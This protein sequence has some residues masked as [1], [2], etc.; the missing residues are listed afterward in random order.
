MNYLLVIILI[1]LLVL[2]HELGHLL[3]ARWVKMPVARFSIG[4]G[5]RLWGFRRGETEYWLSLLPVG[6]YVLPKVADAEGFLMMPLYQRIIF[7]LGGPLA[8]I[9]LPL[10]LFILMN[11]IVSGFSWTGVFIKPFGQTLGALNEFMRMIPKVLTH[12]DQ[13]TGVVGIVAQGGPFVGT[14]VVRGL[15]FCIFLSLNLAVFN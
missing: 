9:L 8:N 4:F 6:G 7:A 5:P 13:S 3:A 10:F 1:G 15:R 11:I 14:S 2:V 12:L